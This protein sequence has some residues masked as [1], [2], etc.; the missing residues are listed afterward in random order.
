VRAGLK[1]S[2]PYPLKGFVLFLFNCTIVY[3]SG[4]LI[5]TIEGVGVEGETAN[6]V[7]L[8]I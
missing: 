1:L 8:V 4:L 7:G 5:S 2:L 6:L 3:S